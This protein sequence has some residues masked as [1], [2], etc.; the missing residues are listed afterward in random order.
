MTKGKI[1]SIVTNDILYDQRVR[2]I[3]DSLIDDGFEVH[4][5]GRKKLQRKS[6]NARWHLLS[7]FFQKSKWFYLE[8]NI[9]VF[10]F[11]LWRSF[12]F[13]IANDLDTLLAV[14][15]VSIIKGKKFVFDGHEIFTEVPELVGRSTAKKVWSSIGNWAVPS[16]TLCLTV[17]GSIQKVLAEKY[18]TE[19]HVIMNRPVI[20]DVE[21]E[22]F[23][24]R[25]ANRI[26]LYQGAVNRGR[27][28]AETIEACK[29]IPNIKFIIAGDG[30][31]FTRIKSSLEQTAYLDGKVE[32]LGK[33]KPHD[34]KELTKKA[35]VG[36]NVLHAESL[37]YRLSLAN[38]FFD[39]AQAGVPS[40]NMDFPEYATHIEDLKVGVCIKDLQVQTI[41]SAIE[42]ILDDAIL[43][44]EMLAA[45]EQARRVWTWDKE[46]EK[47]KSL[48][49]KI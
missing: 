30:N 11:L 4:L 7:C 17:N 12:D 42:E 36:I 10:F 34:L 9:R 39:Y 14:K 15:L 23:T 21:F 3:S 20:Q 22:E 19:F 5:V 41:K 31:E 6:A 32:L 1:Y 24:N 8:F 28:I 2:R 35:S 43:Y 25:Q 46:A 29:D 13:L 49:N 38:K 40:I 27:G 26:I 45:C 48:I 47:L 44:K 18:Q 16:A 33:L 37:N